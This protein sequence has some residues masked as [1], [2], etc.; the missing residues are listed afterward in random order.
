[1]STEAPS[2]SALS[3]YLRAASQGQKPAPPAEVLATQRKYGFGGKI[4]RAT[5]MTL[6]AAFALNTFAP[7]AEAASQDSRTGTRAVQ[8]AVAGAIAGA[9]IGN[10]S[11]KGDA[12]K[13]A[14]IGAGAGLILGAVLGQKETINNQKRRIDD[15]GRTIDAQ[16]RVVDDQGR[17]IEQQARTIEQQART[18][19][20]QRQAVTPGRAC[21]GGHA[22][23][24]VRDPQ[25]ETRAAATRAQQQ[26]LNIRRQ[27]ESAER[28]R[29]QALRTI[30]NANSKLSQLAEQERQAAAAV[31]E[32]ETILAQTP[33]ATEED[34][35]MHQLPAPKVAQAPTVAHGTEVGEPGS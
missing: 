10:N 33:Q 27:M 17:V 2:T 3:S 22:V 31:L 34:L 23:G 18:I 20:Q 9:V 32:I 21:K 35:A 6:L 26:L 15:Q 24:E 12:K 19:E 25:A 13:G 4:P 11:G 30:E 1:M 5:V 28:A 29:T 8:G 7:T 14:A 16:G